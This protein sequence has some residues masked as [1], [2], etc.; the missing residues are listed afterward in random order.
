[1]P[2][3][4]IRFQNGK[5]KKQKINTFKKVLCCR[6]DLEASGGGRGRGRGGGVPVLPSGLVFSFKF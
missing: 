4:C 2:S 3:V 6:M 5:A 1:M